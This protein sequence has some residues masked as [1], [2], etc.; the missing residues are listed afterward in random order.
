MRLDT[1]SSKVVDAPCMEAPPGTLIVVFGAGEEVREVLR[2]PVCTLGRSD[3]KGPAAEGGG[4]DGL[5]EDPLG[6]CRVSGC[7][8][9]ANVLERAGSGWDLLLPAM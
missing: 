4:L 2:E 7:S 9:R 6:S 1:R 5:V 8:E 3:I